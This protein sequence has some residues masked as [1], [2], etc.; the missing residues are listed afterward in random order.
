[1]PTDAPIELKVF[2]FSFKLRF[3]I[4][5]KKP[6]GKSLKLVVLDLSTICFTR[7]QLYAVCSRVESNQNLYIPTPANEY[8]L[9]GGSSTLTDFKFVILLS[10]EFG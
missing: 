5:F 10:L 6:Q 8:C 4:L 3:G 9:P 1:M 2:Q 7:A